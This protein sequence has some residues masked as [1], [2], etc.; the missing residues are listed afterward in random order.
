MIQ[1]AG[2]FIGDEMKF[3]DHHR[4][5]A[6]D[7]ARMEKAFKKYDFHVHGSAKDAVKLAPLF[8]TEN[9]PL[10]L[11]VV[12]VEIHRVGNVQPLLAAMVSKIE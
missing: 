1:K 10:S 5:S 11:S 8:E 6:A 3:R 2:E 9:S 7:L 4:Y 12:D